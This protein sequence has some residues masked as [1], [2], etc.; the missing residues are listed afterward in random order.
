MDIKELNSKLNILVRQTRQPVGV[1]IVMSREEYDSFDAVEP[2]KPLMYCRAV[3]AAGAGH[4]VKITRALGGCNGSNRALGLTEPDP[5]FWTGES[6]KKLGLYKD[7][8]VAAS[9]AHDNPILP[10]V[11]YGIVAMPLSCFETEPDVIILVT[12]SREAMR[13]LQGYTYVYGL[14]HGLNMSG[15]QA[16]CVESTVTPISTQEL[17]VSMLCSGTRH[18]ARWNDGEVMTGVPFSKAEGLVEGL[19]GTVNAIEYDD[20]KK[21]IEEG[22][23]L[24]GYEDI[25]IIYG[26]TY[27]K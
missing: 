13:I 14:T 9:V 16:V 21:E 6:G 1:R 18:H 5:S 11:T 24:N 2:V 4:P 27:F 25:G 20:R 23:K 8:S 22:F 12:N 3:K 17:N 15:N 19:I 7:E 10:P 26:K